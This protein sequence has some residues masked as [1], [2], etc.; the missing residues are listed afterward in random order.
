MPP[1]P[2]KIDMFS[3]RILAKVGGNAV[4]FIFPKFGVILMVEMHFRRMLSF[5]IFFV[6]VYLPRDLGHR[7][8]LEIWTW[9]HYLK[10]PLRPRP[11]VLSQYS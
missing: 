2:R 5:L 1:T 3:N 7:A 11:S 9:G 10:F 6:N 4:G 8:R